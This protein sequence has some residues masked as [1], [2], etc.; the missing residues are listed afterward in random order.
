MQSLCFYRF[1]S[2]RLFDEESSRI[3]FYSRRG[4]EGRRGGG[5]EGEREGEGKIG[6]RGEDVYRETGTC[7]TS[8]STVINDEPMASVH[9]R[10]NNSMTHFRRRMHIVSIH[11]FLS[12]I[13][14]TRLI[15]GQFELV[16][17]S[18]FVTVTEKTPLP[19]SSLSLPPPSSPAPYSPPPPLGR[20]EGGRV[21]RPRFSFFFTNNAMVHDEH[22]AVRSDDETR[23]R[24][25]REEGAS[26]GCRWIRAETAHVEAPS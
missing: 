26:R 3:N 10:F 5:R 13:E 8:R 11:P 16:E 18:F 14:L 12:F 15:R 21:F 7:L 22:D 2:R 1:S 25:N 9:L 17:V 19:C 24:V 6:G 4:G 20:G 23:I